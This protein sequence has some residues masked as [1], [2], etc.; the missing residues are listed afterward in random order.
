M[1]FDLRFFFTIFCIVVSSF[2]AGK[3]FK[4]LFDILKVAKREPLKGTFLDRAK[5]FA[6]N[7]LGQKKL[8][9]DF[10][11]GLQHAIIFWGFILITIGTAEHILEGLYHGFSFDFL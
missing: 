2:F 3:A 1:K 11:P 4:K 7:V 10:L 8:F 5:V 6:V 9:K